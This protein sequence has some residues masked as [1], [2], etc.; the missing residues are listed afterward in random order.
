MKIY[1]IANNKKFSI[2]LTDSIKSENIVRLKNELNLY[3]DE[4]FYY[5]SDSTDSKSFSKKRP[6]SFILNLGNAQVDCINDTE[7]VNINEEKICRL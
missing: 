5:R 7:E 6:L 1:F 2:S 4:H 3:D